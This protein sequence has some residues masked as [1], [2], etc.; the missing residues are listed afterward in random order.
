MHDYSLGHN[1]SL[2]P[3]RPGTNKPC[4]AVQTRM[5]ETA[6]KQ[7]RP[8][9][10]RNRGCEAIGIL[11]WGQ[12]RHSAQ[13]SEGDSEESSN[14]LAL[15][16]ASTCT[17]AL[18][19]PWSAQLCTRLKISGWLATRARERIDGALGS[20]GGGGGRCGCCCCPLMPVV[21]PEV[22]DMF[23]M[24]PR[25]LRR[26]VPGGVF[27]AIVDEGAG[28]CGRTWPPAIVL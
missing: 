1:I 8:P 11:E 17:G 27:V 19:G 16:R 22:I 26:R 7:A 25:D 4:W 24:L 3:H 20:L 28:T 9:D 23:A 21:D 5:Q 18:A 15:S 10:T 12:Q 13:P 2:H 6:E 14:S